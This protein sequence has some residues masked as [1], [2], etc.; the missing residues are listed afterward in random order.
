MAAAAEPEILTCH[1]RLMSV[2]LQSVA[3]AVYVASMIK[4]CRRALTRITAATVVNSLIVTRLDNCNSLLAGCTKQTLDKLQRVLNCSARVL[5]GG[6]SRHHVTPLLHVYLYWL[7]ARERISFKLCI[8]VNKTLRGLAPCYVHSC[9]QPFWPPFCCS[10]W[11]GRT[12]NK[13]TTRKPCI[14]CGWSDHLEQSA[15]GHSLGT[16]IINVQKHAQDTSVFSFL[17]HWLTVSRVRAANFVRR[18]CS[19]S[20]HVTA[21]YKLSFYY[22]YYY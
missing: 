4:S 18:L 13:A 8:L 6:D 21:P 2:S 22:Y 9:S 5:F 20:S 7:R 12:Q 19:D 17:L 14:L 3:T 1:W 15:T 16:Y 11:F 10:W